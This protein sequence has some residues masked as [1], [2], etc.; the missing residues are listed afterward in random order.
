VAIL[1]HARAERRG[2]NTILAAKLFVVSHAG[3]L[4]SFAIPRL[5]GS[6]LTSEA[7]T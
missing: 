1:I 4:Q 2:F 3:L 7:D 6:R 5:F